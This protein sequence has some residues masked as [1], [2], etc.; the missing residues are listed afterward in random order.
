MTLASP[1]RYVPGGVPRDSQPI[2]RIVLQIFVPPA[3]RVAVTAIALLAIGGCRDAPTMPEAV[4]QI[5][6]GEA[7][8][9]I[10]EPASLPSL[11]DLIPYVTDRS[12]ATPLLPRLHALTAAAREARVDG[13]LEQAADLDR[14]AVHLAVASMERSPEPTLLFESLHA[15]GE[16]SDRVELGVDLS[17]YPEIASS[18]RV[19]RRSSDA[20]LDALERGDTAVA[21]LS[22]MQGAEAVRAHSPTTVALRVLARAETRLREFEGG[23]AP[24]DRAIHLVRSARREL[25]AGDPSRALRRALYALQLIDGRQV[26]DTPIT[27]V[28]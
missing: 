19:V 4:Q 21:V 8:M 24:V 16:W 6:G 20:A 25:I 2:P 11:D 12:R 28:R 9:A 14:E 17:V 15:L 27:Q 22:I 18:L 3:R 13:R 5:A 7:W 23:V 26:S 10:P 1:Q